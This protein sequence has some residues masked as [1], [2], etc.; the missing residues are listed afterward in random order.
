[1]GGTGPN[2]NVECPRPAAHYSKY[3]FGQSSMPLPQ[4]PKERIWIDGEGVVA[5]LDGFRIFDGHY[6]VAPKW[7]V[8]PLFNLPI[9]EL[10]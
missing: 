3:V 4:P 1:M 5:V 2:F 9:N 6:L 8:E 10:A 7:H